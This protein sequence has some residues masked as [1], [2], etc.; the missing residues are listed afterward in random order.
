MLVRRATEF[1]EQHT[2]TVTSWPAFA[3]AVATGWARALHCGLP[4]CEAEI[5]AATAA[6]PRCIPLEGEPASGTCVR[7]DQPAAYAKR[8][9][10]GR[11]Y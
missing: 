5:K 4:D 2:A 7:C 9:I 3:A 1:R 11:A 8:V 6:T 10:F